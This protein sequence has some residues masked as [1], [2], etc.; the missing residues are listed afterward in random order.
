ML[1]DVDPIVRHWAAYGI[2]LVGRN[3]MDLQKTLREFIQQE[4]YSANRVMA[5]QALSIC[6]DPRA[7]YEVLWEEIFS[8]VDESK[9]LLPHE[10]Q[11]LQRSDGTKESSPCT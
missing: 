9:R 6:G 2:Y 1:G 4:T 5:A 11:A 8:Q 3:D 10:R 7:A